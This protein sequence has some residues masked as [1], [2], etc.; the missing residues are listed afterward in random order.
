MYGCCLIIKLTST[1]M[2]NKTICTY[3][4][5]HYDAKY[6]FELYSMAL[7]TFHMLYQRL[8]IYFPKGSVHHQSDDLCSER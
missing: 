3:K 1:C 8:T 4:T 2:C 6:L 7:H 5:Y